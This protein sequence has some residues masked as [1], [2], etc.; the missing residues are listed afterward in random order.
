ATNP[1]SVPQGQPLQLTATMNDT[2]RQTDPWQN[3]V[4]AEYFVLPLHGPTPPGEPGTGTPM[5]PQDG[6]WNSPIE[7]V[8]ATVDT[9]ALEPGEYIIA[10]R[11]KD[12]NN[13]W[14]PFTAAF[15]TVEPAQ[16]EP[17]QIVSVTTETLGCQVSFAV[18]LSGTPPFQYD[19]DFGA[20]GSSTEPTPTVEF[21][22][23]GT[24]PYTLT[25]TNC[26]PP[27]QDVYTGTVT[28]SCLP[29]CEPVQGAAIDFAP[30]E[31]FVFR[32]VA[33]TGS[34]SA[35]DAPFT[36]TWAFGDGAWGTGATTTHRYA[37]AGLY[38]VVLTVTNCA[39]T[40]SS[41]ATRSVPVSAFTIYLPIVAR[42]HE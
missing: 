42:N 11:G 40:T 22:A 8:V 13:S 23:S 41:T 34:V 14:G 19:W 25:V 4:A 9:S 1:P 38:T 18:E 17:A 28:V 10:V 37:R 29:G 16:C 24:Y 35:G 20:M 2:R 32:T 12:A 30:A 26:D 6:S 7:N 36:F 5:N 27:V 33:F 21:P 31:P 3:I 15:F 39:G